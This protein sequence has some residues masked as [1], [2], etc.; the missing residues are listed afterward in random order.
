MF[1]FLR[2][3]CPKCS[4]GRLK[5]VDFIRATTVD[6]EG[7]RSPD[8]WGYYRCDTCESKMKIN[9]DGTFES[10]TKKEWSEIEV[11]D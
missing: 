2:K 3:K 11:S 8:S 7:Q 1:R 10:P 5:N 9:A 4:N 6:Q